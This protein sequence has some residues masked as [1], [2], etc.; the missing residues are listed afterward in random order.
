M[1]VNV[2]VTGASGQIGQATV[3]R[4]HEA[5][6]DV[7]AIALREPGILDRLPS[8]IDAVV[9]LGGQTN[10]YVARADISTDVRDSVVTF[11]DLLDRLR[12]ARRPPLVILA[13]T[14]TQSTTQERYAPTTFYDV[15][16]NASQMYLEQ[17]CLEGWV[18]G[19]TLRLS[20]VYGGITADHHSSP[21]GFLNLCIA[22][23]LAGETI[24]IY[25]DGSQ[26][27]DYVHV[28]DVAELITSAV[29]SSSTA[30]PCASYNV[31][32]GHST[33]LIS[34]VELVIEIVQEHTGRRAPIQHQ[35]WPTAAYAIE[36]RSA[37]VDPRPVRTVYGWTPRLDLTAGISRTIQAYLDK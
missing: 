8:S 22:R 35:P 14:L 16:K 31:G 25:G 23:A 13:G 4:L 12:E 20:N 1:R 33:T 17:A 5:G 34:A 27:R 32:S 2:L 19:L 28:D 24:T 26:Q 30:R 3:A 15:A 11:V 37:L 10:A 6:H 9:H 21:R 7:Q 18:H 36:T 29:N